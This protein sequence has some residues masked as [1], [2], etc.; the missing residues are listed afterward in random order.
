LAARLFVGFRQRSQEYGGWDSLQCLREGLDE[1]KVGVVGASGIRP[2]FL[3]LADVSHKLVH[4]ND[5]RRMGCEQLGEGFLPRRRTRSVGVFH[6]V[7]ARFAAQ[8]PCELA[9]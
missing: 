8:L 2:A 1:G 3:K 9:P 6:N 4:E 5:T 7:I